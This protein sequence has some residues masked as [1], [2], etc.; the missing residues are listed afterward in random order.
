[1]SGYLGNTPTSVPLT[2][3]DI[4]NGTIA[5]A[6]LSATGTASASTFLRG[7][8][9]WTAV[10]SDFVKLATTTVSSAVSSV[11]FNGY[12][13]DSTYNT[14]KIFVN[15]L[16]LSSGDSFGMRINVSNSAVS[17]STYYYVAS[18]ANLLKDSSGGVTY[19]ADNVA[20]Y[21]NLTA[22][23]GTSQSSS[24]YTNCFEVMF[25]NPTQTSSSKS[26]SWLASFLSQNATPYLI[27]QKGFGY[28]TG[29]SALTGVTFINSAGGNITG[30]IFS[31]YGLKK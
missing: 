5:L 15:N 12:F 20:S 11:A 1:M 17:T 29:T 10:S 8:N 9:S 19:R 28:N 18:E 14:Y 23:W 13:D 4:Q 16:S 26:F 22:G 7:D 25:Q 3:A 21:I 31:L 2:S 6:D 27:S 24:T 30:G